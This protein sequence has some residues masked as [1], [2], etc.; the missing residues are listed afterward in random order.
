MARQV[1]EVR[2][3]PCCPI[4]HQRTWHLN[5]PVGEPE[6]HDVWTADLRDSL[7]P[8]RAGLAF[9]PSGAERLNADIG[10]CQ[11]G[12]EPPGIRC[13]ATARLSLGAPS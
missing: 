8:L 10:P 1:V 13:G 2:F 6:A 5:I 7:L 3:V 4:R 11:I 9:S 12:A